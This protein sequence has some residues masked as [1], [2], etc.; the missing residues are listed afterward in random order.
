M[1]DLLGL[2]PLEAA[3]GR[4]RVPE[5]LAA[6]RG[7]SEAA[8]DGAP[9]IAHLDQSWGQRVETTS[10]TV[11]VR[12]RRYRYVQFRDAKGEIRSEELF[13]A[14]RDARERENR[15]E[16]EGEVAGRMRAHTDE[17]LKQKPSWKGA[18]RP[19]EIDEIQLNQL[20]A[21]GYAI[22]AK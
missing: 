14:S 15:L 4:S 18:A 6:I 3:D 22:P 8:T 1:L 20:R 7:S 12:E 11:A 13:D 5:L 16:A 21:L 17:Y 2:P 19:L 10:P 9:S